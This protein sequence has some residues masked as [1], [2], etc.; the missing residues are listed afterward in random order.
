MISRALV[1]VLLALS[2]AAPSSAAGPCAHPTVTGT[3]RND[4]LRGTDGP[5]VIAG[6]GGN[7]V[8]TGLGGDDVLCGGPGKDRLRGGPGDDVLLGGGD[9]KEAEDTDYYLYY[10]DTL[11]G[12]PGSDTLDGGLDPRHDG[13]VDEVTFAGLPD[14]VTVDLAEGTAVSGTDTDTVVGPVSRVTGTDHDDVLLG[15]DGDDVLVGGAGSDRVEGRGGDDSLVG[16][17]WAS[18]GT[19]SAPNTLLG[20]PGD[21]LLDG[22]LGADLLRGGSGGDG[23]QGGRGV[24]RSY[25]GPG[26]D[27]VN[28]EAGPEAG[29]VLDGGPGHDTL[30]GLALADGQGRFRGH[31]TGRIDMAAGTVHAELGAVTWDVALRGFED[32]SAP[33]GDR[34][35]VLGTDGPDTIYAGFFSTPVRLYGRGGNDRLYG[36]DQ[37]DVLNG[38]PGR[39]RAS[40]WGG[41]DRY[42]SVERVRDR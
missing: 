15:S 14:A 38:G 3:D 10:G 23:L 8:L 35:V 33:R 19:D 40:G 1:L 42:V 7:D 32:V 22:D 21:D 25:G 20:G 12:G 37:P 17:A 41:R 30:G 4:R 2:F 9:A 18:D 36:S 13:S 11:K 29:H 26:A 34:W 31:V 28:D 27:M 6:L 5:D 16:S 24:D 39:D